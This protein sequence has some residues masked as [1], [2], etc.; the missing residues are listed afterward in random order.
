M[1]IAKC[2]RKQV[3]IVHDELTN[4]TNMDFEL[5]DLKCTPN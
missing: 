2:L 4:A 5:R 3:F 1:R